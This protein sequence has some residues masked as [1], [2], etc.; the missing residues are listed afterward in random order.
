MTART[1]FYK[2]GLLTE[3]D[4]HTIEHKLQEYFGGIRSKCIIVP[5]VSFGFF[6]YES[7]LLVVTPT[8]KLI[9]LEI[10]SSTDGIFVILSPIKEFYFR[11][12]FDI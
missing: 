6:K 1:K 12:K 9:E 5:N 8:G 11:N 10:N 7:D 3:L 4:V 2:N